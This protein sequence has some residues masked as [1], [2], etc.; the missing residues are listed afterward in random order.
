M[1]NGMKFKKVKCQILH[2]GQSNA[3][4]RYKLGEAQL[5]SSPAEKDL[6][7]LVNSRLSMREQCALAAQRANH[8]LGGI[9]HSITCWS[10]EVIFLVYLVLVQRHLGYCVQFWAP[11]FKKDMKVLE[12][13]QRKATKLV[14][15]PEGMSYEKQR[16]TLGFCRLEKRRLTGNLIAL[17]SLL[18]KGRGR[19]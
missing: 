5:E 19:C 12:C 10:R 11:K 18:R 1:I 6:G 4:H 16:R 14:A 15:G 17:Y 8:I 7:V 9:K 3:G 13:I 2:I